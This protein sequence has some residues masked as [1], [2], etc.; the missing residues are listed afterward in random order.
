MNPIF[1][2]LP[3]LFLLLSCSSKQ[4]ETNNTTE[5]FELIPEPD[6]ALKEQYEKQSGSFAKDTLKSCQ[7][8]EKFIALVRYM[9]SSSCHGDTLMPSN[10]MQFSGITLSPESYKNTLLHNLLKDSAVFENGSQSLASV[11]Y[12][13]KYDENFSKVKCIWTYSW[14]TPLS[15]AKIE[16]TGTVEEWTFDSDVSATFAFEFLENEHKKIGFPFFKTAS[17]YLQ[18][19]KNLFMFH[20][21]KSGAEYPNKNFYRWMKNKT[22][23]S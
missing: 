20:S 1:K 12:D 11:S 18:S 16:R 23:F 8:S 22:A 3:V 10:A 2:I 5:R 9:D 19:G 6:K 13:K 7:P 4:S 14:R 21:E 17:F 15:K